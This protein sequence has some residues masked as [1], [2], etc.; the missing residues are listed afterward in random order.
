LHCRLHYSGVSDFSAL[1]LLV[2]R[3][4]GRLQIFL[5]RS[6]GGE[7]LTLSVVSM[8]NRHRQKSGKFGEIISYTFAAVNVAFTYGTFI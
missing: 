8:K 7:D 5:E 1:T 4:E 6:S 3:H 2:R